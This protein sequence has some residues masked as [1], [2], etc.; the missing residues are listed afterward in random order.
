LSKNRLA[1]LRTTRGFAILGQKQYPSAL[2]RYWAAVRAEVFQSSFVLYLYIF[3]SIGQRFRAEEFQIPQ[4]R[5]ALSLYDMNL[6]TLN[7][8]AFIIITLLALGNNSFCQE[9]TTLFHNTTASP[10]KRSPEEKNKKFY[11]STSYLLNLEPTE[12]NYETYYLLACT[13]WELEKLE[14]AKKIF[15][16][17]VNSTKTLYK[18]TYYHSSDIQGDTTKNRYGYGSFSSNHMNDACLY[19]TKIY[20]EQKKFDSSYIYLNDAVKKYE[21]TYSCGTGYYTQQNYYRFL[22]GLCYEGLKK[23]KELLDLL[24]PYCF[25]WQNQTLLRAIKRNYSKAEIIKNLDNAIKTIVCK[26]DNKT[27]SAFV[28]TN[29][30]EENQKAEEIEYYSGTGKMILFGKVIDLPS[31][32]LNNGE[33]LTK[34]YYIKLFKESY[35]YRNLKM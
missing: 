25:D 21:V 1:W 23:E 22:Y 29:V 9:M 5:K 12:K 6:N 16:A 32:D 4:H 19:L 20:I 35:F 10:F 27:S 28:I 31:P 24:L 14:E 34:Q 33:R 13:M 18:D 17:F 3:F 30:G 11:D 15:L 8:K 26:V 2:V 7:I